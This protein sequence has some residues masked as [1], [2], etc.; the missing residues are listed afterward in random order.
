MIKLHEG[1]KEMLPFVQVTITTGRFWFEYWYEVDYWSDKEQCWCHDYEK[2]GR[3]YG[4]WFTLNKAR[5][6]LHDTWFEL[7]DSFK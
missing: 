7:L 1:S 4:L 2:D 3:G 6:A 5:K